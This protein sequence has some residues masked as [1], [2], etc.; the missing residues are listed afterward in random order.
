MGKWE[1][2]FVE[3][4]IRR[5]RMPKRN[6]K[7]GLFLL[8]RDYLVGWATMIGNECFNDYHILENDYNMIRKV[9]IREYNRVINA[10]SLYLHTASERK[11]T[12]YYKRYK[13]LTN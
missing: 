4:C 13:K 7:Y 11:R 1:R 2:L 3:G 5:R 10:D 12:A 6:A 9:N 8:S